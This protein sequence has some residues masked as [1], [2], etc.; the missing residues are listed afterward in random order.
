M[1]S[2]TLFYCFT[3]SQGEGF[4]RLVE[5]VREQQSDGAI[6]G[7]R[8]QGRLHELRSGGVR[9]FWTDKSGRRHRQMSHEHTGPR[10]LEEMEALR[11]TMVGLQNNSRDRRQARPA[12]VRSSVRG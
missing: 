11:V 2:W 10:P 4:S 6:A 7:T 9:P 8:G 5:L 1:A 12:K 3:R